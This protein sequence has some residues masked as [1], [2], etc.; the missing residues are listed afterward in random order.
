M[1]A[2]AILVLEDGTVFEGRSIGVEGFAVGEVVF[3]TAMTGYQEMLTDPSLRGQILTLTYPL[4]G[5]YGETERDLESAQ[6]QVAGFVVRQLAEHPSNWHAEGKLDGF[7]RRHSVVG[8]EG[9]DTRALTRRLRAQGVMMGAIATGEKPDRV[10]RG[11]RKATQYTEI[12]FVQQVSTKSPYQWS[13]AWRAYAA[14]GELLFEQRP[15]V[16][17]IDYG[18]K[19]NIL[20]CLAERGC[21]PIVVP[22]DTSAAEVLAYRPAGVLLSPGPGNPQLLGYAVDT[23]RGLIGKVPIMGICIGHQLI[24][25]AMGGGTFKLKFGHRG[26]NH[27]VKDLATGR[28]YITSQNH[29]FALDADSI[30]GTGLRVSQVSL[31]DGTM[32]AMEHESL[33]IFSIQYHSEANPG[34]RDNAYL[35]DRFLEVIL[36]RAPRGEESRPSKAAPGGMTDA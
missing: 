27:P 34:P 16:V 26:A 12:D 3:S 8:I 2:P 22:C 20:R 7:L 4:I 10:L 31:N 23:I 11:L 24:G 15:R 18:M 19:L 6:V 1:A 21:E 17:V 36:S 14:Q 13:G 5:N 25:L 35:F 9:I 29:G 28:V 32:E 30:A 33:P